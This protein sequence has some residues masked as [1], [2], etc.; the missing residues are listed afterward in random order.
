MVHVILFDAADL[1]KL[2]WPV[3]VDCYHHMIGSGS[4]RRKYHE[5]FSEA[6]RVL[7]ARFK[8]AMRRGTS[9]F[10]FRN[11]AEIAVIKNACR[12]FAEN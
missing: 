1:A 2:Q 7:I 4:I 11:V 5:Q 10:M 3:L 6:E 8:E 12:F 9:E